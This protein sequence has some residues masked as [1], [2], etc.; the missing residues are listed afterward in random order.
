MIGA[1]YT[2]WAVPV[3]R[4]ILQKK[5]YLFSAVL[6]MVTNVSTNPMGDGHSNG[7]AG[8]MPEMVGCYA[9]YGV[10]SCRGVYTRSLGLKAGAWPRWPSS[11]TFRNQVAY[12]Y[13]CGSM[14]VKQHLVLGREIQALTGHEV[15]E[16]GV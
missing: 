8:M 2:A 16:S 7:E 4:N 12:S 13:C 10:S 1:T 14:A 11:G 6:K 3:S 5:P 9:P 15:G